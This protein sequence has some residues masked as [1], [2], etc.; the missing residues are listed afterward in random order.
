MASEPWDRRRLACWS[1]QRPFR[2]RAGETPA[3]PGFRPAVL[4][5]INCAATV[6]SA[7]DAT[8]VVR[9]QRLLVVDRDL[10]AGFDIAQRAEENVIVKDLHES[11]RTA[12]VV[13]VMRPVS[14]AT[15]VKTPAVVH[16]AN[17]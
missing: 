16:L 7:A 15:P 8:L 6:S 2:D 14:A 9:V 12:R 5:P 4:R 11:V 17:P 10:F 3:V 13:N 1:R